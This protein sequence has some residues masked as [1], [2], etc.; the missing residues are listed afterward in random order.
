MSYIKRWAMQE[1]L[2]D[3][4]TSKFINSS[5]CPI[6]DLNLKTVKVNE[7]NFTAKYL[8][9]I[10]RKDYVHGLVGWFDTYFSH[11]HV[12]VKLSTSI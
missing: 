10:N 12:P 8:L 7:L 3:T 1:P 6:L 11:G 5:Q 9:K 4:V 2:V